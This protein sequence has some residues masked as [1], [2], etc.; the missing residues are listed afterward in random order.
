MASRGVTVNAVAPGIIAS[1]MADAAFDAK[2]IAELVPAKRAGTPDEVAALVG[3]SLRRRRRLHHRPGD[4]DQRRDD[5]VVGSVHTTEA[6]LFSTLLQLA[7]IVLAAL[8][9]WLPRLQ[10]HGEASGTVAAANARYP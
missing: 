9:R 10:P 3:V 2:Q 5:V 8:R 1:P 4:L 7:V 6:L